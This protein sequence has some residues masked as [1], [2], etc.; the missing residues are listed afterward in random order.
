MKRIRNYI[1]KNI[2]LCQVIITILQS[3]AFGVYLSIYSNQL[4][5]GKNFFEIIF[6]LKPYNFW[7][8]LVIFSIIMQIYFAK[9]TDNSKKQ[10]EIELINQILESA[11]KSLI[12]QEPH[13]HIRAIVTICD[14]KIKKRRT[15]YSYNISANP[16]RTAEYDIFFGVTGKAIYNKIP[17]AEELPDNHMELYD[18]NNSKYIAKEVKSIL[19]APIFSLDVP[20][21]VI[22]VLSFDSFEKMEVMR[23]NSS[24]SKELAQ[25]WA[26]ILSHLIK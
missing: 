23:F 2:L 5:K 24:I 20:E 14:Y 19:A 13:K 7:L 11:C 26:D 4:I 18:S 12:Y 16:E 25:S 3:I 15:V 10:K 22:G 17:I 1:K 6:L 8:F 9:I 21:K